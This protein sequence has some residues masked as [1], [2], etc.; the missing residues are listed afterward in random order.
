MGIATEYIKSRYDSH[1]KERTMVL[2]NSIYAMYNIY[3]RSY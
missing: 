3:C 2:F 1:H